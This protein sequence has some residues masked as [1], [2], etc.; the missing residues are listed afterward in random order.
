MQTPQAQVAGIGII[1]PGLPSWAAAAAVLAGAAPYREA[2]AQIDAPPLLPPAERRRCGL[3]VRLALA[4][5]LEAVGQAGLDPGELRSVFA[6]SGGDGANC[7]EILSELA[8]P[9]PALSPTRFHNSVHNAAAGYWSIATGARAASQVLCAY[10]GS[11]SAGLL[12]A[13]TQVTLEACPVLLIAYDTPYL[14]PLASKRPLPH[15]FAV[16]LVLTAADDATA[17][18]TAPARASLGC[19]RAQLTE[20]GATALPDAPLERLRAAVPAARS[21]PLLAA[22]ARRAAGGPGAAQPVVLDYLCGPQLAVTVS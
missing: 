9:D 13:L 3:T 8:G 10:D 7:H 18:G 21:L 6:S 16:A 12:E 22:L 20:G 17:V 4:A 5:G 1:G 14:E 2:P 19:I 11:F 15:A